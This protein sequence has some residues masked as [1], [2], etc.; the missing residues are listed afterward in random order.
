MLFTQN[1]NKNLNYYNLLKIS[2]LF[3]LIVDIFQ[4]KLISMLCYIQYLW[5]TCSF[6]KHA[7]TVDR[8][9]A[10]F[11]VATLVCMPYAFYAYLVVRS[12]ALKGVRIRKKYAVER[13]GKKISTGN[14]LYN[15]KLQK[16]FEV[17]LI[18]VNSRSFLNAP[19]F[20]MQ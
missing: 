10:S 12:Y 16:L 7:H 2:F 18:F 15:N 4:T 19:S 20:I 11:L 14:K 13:E 9:W 17:L 8:Y 6:G 3:G 1:I 5:M